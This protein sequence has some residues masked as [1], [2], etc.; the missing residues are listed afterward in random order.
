MIMVIHPRFLGVEGQTCQVRYEDQAMA[1][2]SDEDMFVCHPFPKPSRPPPLQKIIH[3]HLHGS[4]LR[5]GRICPS[6]LGLEG[7]TPS[8]LEDMP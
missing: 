3:D 6:F 7:Q 8:S 2:T 1:P 4:L 5:K